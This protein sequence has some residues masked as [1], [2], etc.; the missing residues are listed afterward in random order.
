M[1]VNT[2]EKLTKVQFFVNSV[3]GCWGLGFWVWGFGLLGVGIG[4]WGLSVR[5]GGK[6]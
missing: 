2:T 3:F 4:D 6:V 1:G 5:G